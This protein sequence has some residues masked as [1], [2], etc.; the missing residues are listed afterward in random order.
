MRPPRSCAAKRSAVG[1]NDRSSTLSASITQTRSRSTNRS[2]SAKRLRDPARLLLV[3]V[4]Q[5]VDP[6]FVAVAE[7][8]EELAR[9]D[10]SRHEHQLA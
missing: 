6:V 10:P 9:V 5:P 3:G 4:E 8:A 7:Q 2:A 1:R